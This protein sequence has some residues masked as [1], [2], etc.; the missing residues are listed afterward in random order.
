MYPGKRSF[1]IVLSLAFLGVLGPLFVF[2]ALIIALDDG[3]P[4]F[5]RQERVGR[6]GRPFQL[7][8]FRSMRVGAEDLGSPLTIRGDP[9]ITRVGRFLRR[10]KFD[11]L[12]QFFNVLAGDMTIVGPRPQTPHYVA[13]YTSDQRMVLHLRPGI[14][15]PTSLAFFE[16]EELLAR[17]PEPERFYVEEVIPRKIAMYLDYAVRANLIDDLSVIART[18]LRML[19]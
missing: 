4:V 16:E 15:D 7:W 10:R 14:T 2:I 19:R 6:F 1:D 5:F 8:K 18:A 12:P 17:F 13:R 11:E 3:R 9:R